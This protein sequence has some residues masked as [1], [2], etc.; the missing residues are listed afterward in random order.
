MTAVIAV[1]SAA[2]FVLLVVCITQAVQV[3]KIRRKLKFIKNNKSNM[4]LNTETPF[5]QINELIREINDILDKS[6]RLEVLTQRREN[7]LRST[8]ANLSHDIRTPLTSL[9]GY[10]QLLLHADTESEREQYI[11]IIDERIK[12]LKDILEELFTYTKLQNSDFTLE[13]ESVDI[14]RIFCESVFSFYCEFKSEKIEPK[15]ELYD[16]ELIVKGNQDAFKRVFK[17]IIKNALEHSKG[18]DICISLNKVDDTVVFKCSNSVDSNDE[19]DI[20][21]VFDRFYRSDG[22]RTATS[23]GLGLSI[24]KELVHR[25]KGSITAELEGAVFTVEIKLPEGEVGSAQV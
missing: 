10:F 13:L 16:G 15:V 17:N 23:T 6:R 19:I 21:R 5:R 4:L 9:D 8:V 25:M 11:K 18:G 7:E 3:Y 1:L 24:A 12:A 14:A 22:A 2:V 20:E